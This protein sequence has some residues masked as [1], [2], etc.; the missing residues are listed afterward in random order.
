[1]KKH[2]HPKLEMSAGGESEVDLLR[3]VRRTTHRTV[4]ITWLGVITTGINLGIAL[5]AKVMKKTESVG[6]TGI[7]TIRVITR[8]E[9]VATDPEATQ[10]AV[11]EKVE[12]DTT[13]AVETITKAATV[14]EIIIKA[15]ITTTTKVGQATPRTVT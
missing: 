4:R 13:D 9:V 11:V 7:I 3:A 6:A 15:I 5:G 8:E 1:M 14:P 10:L 2:L 12:V